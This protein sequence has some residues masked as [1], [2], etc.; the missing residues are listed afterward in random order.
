MDIFGG[1]WS[2]VIIGKLHSAPKRFNE[3]CRDLGISTKALSDALKS[4]DGSKVASPFGVSKNHSPIPRREYSAAFPCHENY[5]APKTLPSDGSLF[6][7]FLPSESPQKSKTPMSNI[8][9]SPVFTGF[10]S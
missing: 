8:G 1:K 9:G 7:T 5:P 10:L 3:M 2:F 4:L 6:A